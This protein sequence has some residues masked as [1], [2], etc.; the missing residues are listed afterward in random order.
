MAIF[1]KKKE[2]KKKKKKSENEEKHKLKLNPQLLLIIRSSCLSILDHEG[3][4]EFDD[5]F[6]AVAETHHRHFISNGVDVVDYG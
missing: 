6:V 3:L 2:T 1:K 4:K 5:V